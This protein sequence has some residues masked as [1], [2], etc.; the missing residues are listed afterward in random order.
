MDV[1]RSVLLPLACKSP[2]PEFIE[3]FLGIAAGE[4]FEQECP[5]A[6]L[7]EQAR[8]SITPTLSVRG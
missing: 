8:G 5:L 4:A 7:D 6:V 2:A 3:Y 1:R